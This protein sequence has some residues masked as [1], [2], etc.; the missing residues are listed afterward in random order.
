MWL[1]RCDSGIWG[2][3]TVLAHRV[4][5]A[6]PSTQR[7]TLTHSFFHR[8]GWSSHQKSESAVTN[9][10]VPIYQGLGPTHQK[11]QCSAK[12]VWY[13]EKIPSGIRFEKSAWIRIQIIFGLKN[14]PNMNTHNIRFEKIAW[15]WIR[16]IFGF[17]SHP[18]T[19]TSIRPQVFE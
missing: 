17:K 8:I 16:I 3:I 10:H 18:N 7:R 15:I 19:N 1:T 9:F 2:W 14:Y 13:S 4:V 12:Y 5:L 11:Y 6:A